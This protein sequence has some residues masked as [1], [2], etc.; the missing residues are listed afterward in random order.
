LNEEERGV[1]RETSRQADR[2]LVD[3]RTTM[4]EGGKEVESA[5]KQNTG[6]IEKPIRGGRILTAT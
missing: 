4:M 5:R 3:E 2:R 6:T 1:E